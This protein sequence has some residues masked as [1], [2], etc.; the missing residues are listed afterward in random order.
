MFLEQY[1][2]IFLFSYEI[3]IIYSLIKMQKIDDDSYNA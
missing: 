1:I 2:T 3:Y